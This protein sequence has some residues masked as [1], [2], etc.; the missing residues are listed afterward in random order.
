M[1]AEKDK[2]SWWDNYFQTKISKTEPHKIFVR[3][4]PLEE[5]MGNCTFGEILWLVL[6][7]ELPSEQETKMIEALLCCVVDHQFIASVTPAVRFVA[8]SNPQVIPSV[9]AGILT[10]GDNQF[11]PQLTAEF[12][13]G[14][15]DRMQREG[16]TVKETAEA[17]VADVRKSKSR[18]PGFGHPTHKEFDPRADRLKELAESYGFGK[19]DE[20][21]LVYEAIHKEFQLKSS[22]I[23]SI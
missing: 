23:C 18:I 9:V 20:R 15:Y 7:G 1:G 13:Q 14:A 11:S 5:L 8:S 10:A 2:G 3:G 16:L 6:R 12:I 4:Y 21:T 22:R 19:G 17:V